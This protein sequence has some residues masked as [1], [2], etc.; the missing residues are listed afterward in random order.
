MKRIKLL[1]LAATLGLSAGLSAQTWTL[2][3]EFSDPTF[4]NWV[5]TNS[6]NIIGVEPFYE[7]GDDAYM[8]LVYPEGY[9]EG[10]ATANSA[11]NLET[12]NYGTDFTYGTTFAVR[13]LP[14][15]LPAVGISTVYFQY[16]QQGGLNEYHFGMTTKVP[17]LKD[18]PEVPPVRQLY[19]SPAAWGDYAFL[20]RLSY[21][22][23]FD[24]RDGSGYTKAPNFLVEDYTWYEIWVVV[25]NS[26]GAN[27]DLGGDTYQ[28]YIKG[29]EYATP[30]LITLPPSTPGFP[31]QDYASWR[32]PSVDPIVNIMIA[33]QS[34]IKSTPNQGDP[35]LTDD[36]FI[37][38]GDYSGVTPPAATPR[39]DPLKWGKWVV[40]DD[41][42]DQKWVATGNFLG[43]I[44]LP[45]S[46]PNNGDDHWVYSYRLKTWVWADPANLGADGS[47]WVYIQKGK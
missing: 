19:T 34:G 42:I 12:G 43:T 24:L 32:N 8:H 10:G 3:D 41:N 27:F 13:S 20:F 36:I 40:G 17:V 9:E 14:V 29:G 45:Y 25:T 18:P 11:M 30:T 7:D 47:G 23:T 2:V 44:A 39:V 5:I 1:P 21:D 37:T 22:D 16:Y 26:E 46:Y 38:E 15:S 28:V 31:D 4:S 35:H 33:S 6:N